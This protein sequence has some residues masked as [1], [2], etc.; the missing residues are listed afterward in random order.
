MRAV[1]ASR[2]GDSL[3]A[4]QKAFAR[5]QFLEEG[6]RLFDERGYAEATI[7]ELASRCG[8]AKG[9]IY[10]H[11]PDGKDELVREIYVAIG[12]DFDR[13]FAALLETAGESILDCVDA[14]AEV[15]MAISAE[16]GKGQFFMI[17]APALPSVLGDKLGRTGRGIT[18]AIA[19]R[20]GAAQRAGEVDAAVDPVVVSQLV[21]GMLREAGM[22]VASGAAPDA[23]VKAALHELLTGAL[24]QK[25]PRRAGR[26]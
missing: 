1:L 6:L 8:C 24:V 18:G 20:I 17:S 9:T 21:L 12:E 4:R 5:S 10:A 13:R 15:L 26:R 16:P 3:R 2:T 11:F 23:E 25:R 22:Q 19:E 14:A 7:E